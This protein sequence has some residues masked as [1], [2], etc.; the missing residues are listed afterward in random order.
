[1]GFSRISTAALAA[2][3]GTALL[4]GCGQKGALYLRDNPPAGVKIPRPAAP[5]PIPY[6]VDPSVPDKQD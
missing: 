1:M 6:P 2:A 5:K 3:L 4:A